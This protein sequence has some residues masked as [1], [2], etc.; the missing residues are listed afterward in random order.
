MDDHESL[1]TYVRLLPEEPTFLL[2]REHYLEGIVAKR[3]DSR[4]EPGKRSGSWVKLRY[5][6]GRRSPHQDPDEKENC[7]SVPAISPA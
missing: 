1:Q 3:S 7:Q 6:F 5:N 2:A 4:Y